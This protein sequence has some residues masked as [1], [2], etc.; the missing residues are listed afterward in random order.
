MSVCV[1]FLCELFKSI[2]ILKHKQIE[3][4]EKTEQNSCILLKKLPCGFLSYRSLA[5]GTVE[6]C[7]SHT[8][9][10]FWNYFNNILFWSVW[11]LVTCIFEVSCYWIV[12][13]FKRKLDIPILCLGLLVCVLCDQYTANVITI[14]TLAR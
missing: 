10:L 5:G 2:N 4:Q 3:L 14:K 9:S 7:I 8:S 12:K 13:R 6:V 1:C 11:L